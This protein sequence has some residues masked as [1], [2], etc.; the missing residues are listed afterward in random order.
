MQK[1]QLISIRVEF[2]V[3][4]EV[5]G[6][7]KSVNSNDTSTL[8]ANTAK[9]GMSTVICSKNITNTE[10]KP[11]VPPSRD[12]NMFFILCACLLGGGPALLQDTGLFWS[13]KLRH[14]V[15]KL[16]NKELI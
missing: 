13:G 6:V 9:M 8:T 15:A 3:E 12:S 7:C 16:F 5:T 1:L 4:S 10:E 14:L 11:G 2:G